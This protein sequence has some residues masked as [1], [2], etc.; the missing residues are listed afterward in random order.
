MLRVMAG[1]AHG[2]DLRDYLPTDYQNLLWTPEPQSIEGYEELEFQAVARY[3]SQVK[4]L[5][6]I[7]LLERGMGGLHRHWGGAEPYWRAS[8]PPGSR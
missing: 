1:L 2:P 4:A 8:W 3:G 6:G 7:R 5:G